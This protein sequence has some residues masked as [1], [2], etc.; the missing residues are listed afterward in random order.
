MSSDDF[1]SDYSNEKQERKEIEAKYSELIPRL[2]ATFSAKKFF[3]EH[4]REEAIVNLKM[5]FKTN[6]FDLIKLVFKFNEQNGWSGEKYGDYF[7][8]VFTCVFVEL[9]Q[10]SSVVD[11]DVDQLLALVMSIFREMF[12]GHFKSFFKEYKM[13]EKAKNKKTEEYLQEFFCEGSKASGSNYAVFLD[14]VFSDLT[15]LDIMFK[16]IIKTCL[17]QKWYKLLNETFNTCC[18]ELDPANDVN[19]YI[20]SPIQYPVE[21]LFGKKATTATANTAKSN[22]LSDFK[23]RWTEFHYKHPLERLKKI[24]VKN[25]A[26]DP[27]KHKIIRR[28]VD[29]QWISIGGGAWFYYPE[30]VAYIAF[31]VLFSLSSPRLFKI[32]EYSASL[33]WITLGFV[34][35]DFVFIIKNLFLL[36]TYSYSYFYSFAHWL[37]L[38]NLTLCITA[39]MIPTETLNNKTSFWSFSI[40]YAYINMIFRLEG[41]QIFGCYTYAFRKIM[42]KSIR[43]LP[44]VIL[45]YLG[46]SY[47]FN[48]R[49][50]F[51]T[52]PDE[53]YSDYEVH[54]FG[55]Y[56]ST[57][58]IKLSLMFMG[59]NIE[60][61][62]MGLGKNGSRASTFINYFMLELFL[63]IVCIILYNMFVAIAV[64]ELDDMVKKG[65]NHLYKV[66]CNIIQQIILIQ[67]FIG[68]SEIGFFNKEIFWEYNKLENKNTIVIMLRKVFARLVSKIIR[69]NDVYSH[70]NLV[71]FNGN[72]L[73][74]IKSK[75]KIQIDQN[76]TQVEPIWNRQIGNDLIVESMP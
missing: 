11:F 43:V 2:Y 51:I 17:D 37:E 62:N 8:L 5:L 19:I 47:A 6:N 61:E 16:L 57:N 63:F 50:R 68:K 14:K 53:D 9:A 22:P 10:D 36:F 60:L 71:H 55:A 4:N 41:T 65:E 35:L 34:L 64:G 46:F 15:K 69:W 18:I 31:L 49:S 58:I 48:V 13:Q 66:H 24:S 74:S 45:L 40:A 33:E 32:Y 38:I 72:K 42:L 44:I 27:F 39:I 59:N 75:I 1:L 30:L 29:Y 73:E 54:P 67:S 28:Y 25:E 3:R 20:M 26:D 21:P 52:N 7:E 70:S 76:R 56:I 23:I 12:H